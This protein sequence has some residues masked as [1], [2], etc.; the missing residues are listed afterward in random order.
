MIN[1]AAAQR[2]IEIGIHKAEEVDRSSFAAA[3]AAAVEF[4]LVRGVPGF[5]I[6]SSLGV[7][8]E[9]IDAVER[10]VKSKKAKQRYQDA[11]LEYA[12]A[13][14]RSAEA[15]EYLFVRGFTR[16]RLQ[17]LGFKA[18]IKLSFI[19]RAHYWRTLIAVVQK[20]DKGSSVSIDYGP[21]RG[22]ISARPG[23][24]A[25][26]IASGL[27]VSFEVI[28]AVERTVEADKAIQR[29]QMHASS[30]PCR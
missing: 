22:G 28:H 19:K 8:L 6:A 23:V 16:K 20:A 30:V 3:Q 13:D 12:L 15:A 25:P 2:I 1:L 4:L 10:K 17:A 9:D 18:D 27:G 5:G 29:Y 11:C 24:P 21:G 7:R 14:R 26:E